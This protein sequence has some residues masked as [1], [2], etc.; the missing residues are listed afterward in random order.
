MNWRPMCKYQLVLLSQKLSNHLKTTVFLDCVSLLFLWSHFRTTLM[1]KA[2]SEAL[3]DQA[4]VWLISSYRRAL[5]VSA[6][7]QPKNSWGN[8]TWSTGMY[9]TQ[10]LPHFSSKR[11]ACLT[12]ELSGQ[13]VNYRSGEPDSEYSNESRRL[14][15]NV[16]RVSEFKTSL[17]L[18]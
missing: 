6:F 16:S 2:L 17:Q 4:S 11:S 1:R 3:C 7:K 14:S 9:N 13:F 18:S 5:Q 12:F 15:K 8:K 10:H